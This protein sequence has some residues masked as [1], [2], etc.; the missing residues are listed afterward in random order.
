MCRPQEI[1]NQGFV[2]W[3]TCY[4]PIDLFKWP[5]KHLREIIK[6]LPFCG[7]VGCAQT[8]WSPVEQRSGT[9]ETRWMVISTY[10]GQKVFHHV[11]WP[12]G[13][14]QSYHPHSPHRRGVWLSVT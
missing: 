4:I 9:P 1:R 11:S 2:V 5:N 12:S 10:M 6:M 14:C 7:V 3:G 8:A 13:S